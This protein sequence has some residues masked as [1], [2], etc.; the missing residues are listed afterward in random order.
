MKSRR[1]RSPATTTLHS[2]MQAVM[3]PAFGMQRD[4]PQIGEYLVGREALTVAGPRGGG[5]GGG[6]GAG[7]G[8]EQRTVSARNASNS[9]L[10]PRTE[11][12]RNSVEKERWVKLRGVERKVNRWKDKRT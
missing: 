10:L 6:A 8:G 3:A 1:Y 2:L 5:G 9:K 12:W 11:L 4:F 7:G